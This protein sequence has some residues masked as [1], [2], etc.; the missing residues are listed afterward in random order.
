MKKT[1]LA[2][3]V[4]LLVFMAKTYCQE[5][6]DEPIE[7]YSYK[8]ESRSDKLSAVAGW[9]FIQTNSGKVWEK[10]NPS[11]G[12][13]YMIGHPRE[14]SFLSMRII[15]FSVKSQKYYALGV[16]K[17]KFKPY[18]DF[19]YTRW[20][21]DSLT[22]SGKS[23]DW[24]FFSA[25]SLKRLKE[26]V[27]A[28]DGK[29]YA[30]ISVRYFKT[31]SEAKEEDYQEVYI[32]DKELKNIVLTGNVTA[33]KWANLCKGDS[34]FVINS[35]VL[36]GDTIIRFNVLS[37]ISKGSQPSFKLL[38]LQDSYFE[39]SKRDFSRLFTFSPFVPKEASV[40]AKGYV[41]SG[42]VRNKNKDYAGAIAE[43][44]RAIE[45]DADYAEAYYLRALAKYASGEKDGCCSD[46]SKASLLGYKNASEKMKEL[47]P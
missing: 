30:M 32:N 1:V 43:Y 26:A 6:K 3:P 39:V 15:E 2:F 44:T 18:E 41:S 23:L 37:D 35:Q 7:K 11:A 33:L 4:I 21:Y 9:S 38:P 12:Y 34:L 45:I 16:K 10:S 42:T 36:K 19:K 22:V 40:K 31:N 17:P 27:N 28:A 20:E 14:Y 29:T 24:F 25:A 8:I 47:C 13:N 46:L 5:R